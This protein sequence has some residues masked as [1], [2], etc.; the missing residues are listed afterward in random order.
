MEPASGREG[1]A[2]QLRL[3]Q[4]ENQAL[5]D[6]TKKL[7]NDLEELREF[8]TLEQ[9]EESNS[10]NTHNTNTKLAEKE[11][12]FPSRA[13]PGKSSINNT[14]NANKS[15]EEQKILKMKLLA[16]KLEN[17]RNKSGFE[18]LKA[19][20]IDSIVIKNVQGATT[21]VDREEEK[22]I[23]AESVKDVM[24]IDNI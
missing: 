8:S 9:G 13:S 19:M 17:A 4:L 14:N 1:L 24:I 6:V 22:K 18:D 15:T 20:Y 23:L 10:N 11:N 16:L 12:S 7:Q 5:R 2:V 3:S 21:A